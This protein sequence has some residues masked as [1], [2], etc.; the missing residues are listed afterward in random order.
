MEDIV[1]QLFSFWLVGT[2]LVLG[3][4]VLQWWILRKLHLKQLAAVRARHQSAQQ[5]AATLLQQARLQ[6]AQVQQ[7]L[8]AAREAAKRR[9]RPATAR[10][11][12]TAT[13]RER[14]NKM[15]D[16]AAQTQPALPVDGFADT[17]PSL[18][19]APSTTFGLLQ[20]SSPQ[21]L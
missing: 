8:V 11:P 5:S 3:V 19:F 13:A 21:S 20:R 2:T 7:A 15:L 1:M 18:Q 4:F 17:M 14:L 6:T 10:S 9:Q 16:D 12:V